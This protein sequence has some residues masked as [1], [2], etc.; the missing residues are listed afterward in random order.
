MAK[1]PSEEKCYDYLKEFIP[2]TMKVVYEDTEL[3]Y[4]I[5]SKYRPDYRISFR[6]N[7]GTVCY[8]EYKGG[9]RAFDQ[10]ARAKMVAVKEQY[11]DIKFYI[12]FHTDFKV[13]P[14][15]KDGSFYR[16]S[17]WAKRNGFDFCVGIINIKEE[18]FQ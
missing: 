11:P 12:I 18:W 7:D 15:R 6:K 14:K 17:D 1:N 10:A 13:G 16:A 2:K 5:T 4:T 9:G 8:L 3:E